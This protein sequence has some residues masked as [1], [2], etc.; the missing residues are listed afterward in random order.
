MVTF[1]Y[2]GTINTLNEVMNEVEYLVHARNTTASFFCPP[3]NPLA[4]Y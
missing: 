4:C 1:F 3:V 2:C